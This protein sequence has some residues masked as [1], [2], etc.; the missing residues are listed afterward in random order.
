[1]VINRFIIWFQNIA[2]RGHIDELQFTHTA[3]KI[4]PRQIVAMQCASCRVV[5]AKRAAAGIEICQ[6]LASKPTSAMSCPQGGAVIILPV[7]A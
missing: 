3:L 4:F 2:N 7:G 5:F 1:M 6:E